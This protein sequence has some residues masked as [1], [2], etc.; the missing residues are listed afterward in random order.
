MTPVGIIGGSGLYALPG[1]KPGTPVNTPFGPSAP[2]S[3]GVWGSRDVAFLPRHG[4]H[5]SVLPKDIN[6]RANIFALKAAGVRQ[7]V[8][9][10][11]VGSLHDAIAPGHVVAVDQFLDMTRARPQTFFGD[12]LVAHVS[13]A[14]PTCARLR[15]Q[16]LAAVPSTTT[17]HPTA[18]YVCIEGPQFSTRAES[19]LWRAWGAHVVG[20]TALP[21]TR[22]AREAELC[23]QLLALPT[24]YDAWKTQ[25]APVTAVEVV[26]GLKAATARVLQ[27]LPAALGS[28]G[29]PDACA[30][31]Y[32]LDHALL[33]PEAAIDA[34]TKQRLALL[35]ARRF[36][37]P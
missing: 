32:S 3:M 37:S 23:Y 34:H 30:C 8:A 11:A 5:H 7:V 25:E 31:Q 1:L 35:L 22:L 17:V 15:A 13:L 27:W 2:L 16:L 4:L 18:T 21:E 33:T 10:S 19:H 26:R 6:A 14:D 12:G 29:E 28:L 20:M 9:I 24:D 36:S